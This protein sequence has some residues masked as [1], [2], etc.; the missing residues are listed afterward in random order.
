MESARNKNGH[1]R[2]DLVYFSFKSTYVLHAHSRSDWIHPSREVVSAAWFR[3]FVVDPGI[4]VSHVDSY[5]AK[6][7]GVSDISIQLIVCKHADI[8]NLCTF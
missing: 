6:V 7:C 4:R 5:L 2:S 1:F 3:A 8:L